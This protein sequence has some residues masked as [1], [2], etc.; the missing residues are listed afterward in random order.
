MSEVLFK[1]FLTKQIF[2]KIMDETSKVRGQCS[3]EASKRRKALIGVLQSNFL[4]GNQK[5]N[6]DP[7]PRSKNCKKYPRTRETNKGRGLAW[8]KGKPL[9]S[10]PSSDLFC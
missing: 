3:K 5:E 10:S 7:C 4:L 1:N 9:I 8:F 2:L 6:S